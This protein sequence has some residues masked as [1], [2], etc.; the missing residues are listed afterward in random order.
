MQCIIFHRCNRDGFA[1][2]IIQ[3]GKLSGT[4]SSG[5]I[6][7]VPSGH[8]KLGWD[9]FNNQLKGISSFHFILNRTALDGTRMRPVYPL[10][11]NTIKK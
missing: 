11:S 7:I 9:E 8:G 2:T 4:V 10:N 6:L 3:E 1:G 5:C